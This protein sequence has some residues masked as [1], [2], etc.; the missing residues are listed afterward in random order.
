MR[1][2]ARAAEVWI[3]SEVALKVVGIVAL[4]AVVTAA[5]VMLMSAARVLGL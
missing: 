2:L 1:R 4:I 3:W 5:M